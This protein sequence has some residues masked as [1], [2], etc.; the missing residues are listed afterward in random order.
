M[1]P[2]LSHAQFLSNMS[3]LKDA[4]VKLS[5]DHK[6]AVFTKCINTLIGHSGNDT[7]PESDVLKHLELRKDTATEFDPTNP[8][9]NSLDCSSSQKFKLFQKY[10]MERVFIPI[11]GHGET[12]AQS[13]NKLSV[14][15]LEGFEHMS[16]AIELSET[17]SAIVMNCITIWRCIV[18]VDTATL[19][20]DTSEKTCKPT[21][22]RCWRYSRPRRLLAPATSKL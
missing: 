7:A 9:L 6:A 15:L 13:A 22:Q 16:E 8:T 11:L 3:A 17:S 14:K 4:Q 21:P 2:G 10:V 20:G 19:D 5:S 1:L 12:T 18:A